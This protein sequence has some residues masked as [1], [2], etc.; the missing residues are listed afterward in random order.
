MSLKKPIIFQSTFA[1]YTASDIIGEGGSG[2]IF[3]AVDESGH[4]YAIKALDS[5]KATKEKV[6]RF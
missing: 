3:K 6:K 2:L 1:T 5:A 4:A